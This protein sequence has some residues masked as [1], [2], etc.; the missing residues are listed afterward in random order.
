MRSQVNYEQTIS[1]PIG[2]IKFAP[3]SKESQILGQENYL[4]D[5]PKEFLEG[6]GFNTAKFQTRSLFRSSR[7]GALFKRMELPPNERS[8]YVVFP[9]RNGEPFGQVVLVPDE[10]ET[11]AHA[12]FH[13]WQESLRNRGLGAPI[14]RA[15]LKVLM[16]LQN[17]SSA[18][19]EPHRD[20]LAMNRL[21]VNCGFKYLG[22]SNFSGP[23]TYDFPSKK[24]EILRDCL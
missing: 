19:I 2:D 5:S 16:D 24:Y 9:E 23:V 7:V 22:E 21:M 1:S 8:Y 14:L 3:L 13:I 11:T 20:N 4:Y 10:I 18:L 6:I 17:R 12:H 15:G